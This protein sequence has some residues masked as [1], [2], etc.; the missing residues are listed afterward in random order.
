MAEAKKSSWP[1]FVGQPGAAAVAAIKAE[2]P[3]LEVSTSPCDAMLT[4]D[5]RENRVRIMVDAAGNVV[6]PPTCG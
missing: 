4:M 2:R 6:A 3:E 1:E 5:F